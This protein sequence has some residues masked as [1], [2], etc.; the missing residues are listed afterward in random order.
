MSADGLLT[1]RVVNGEQSSLAMPTLSV[2]QLVAAGDDYY[3]YCVDEA[4]APHLFRYRYDET[5]ATVP[6]AELRVYA[7]EDSPTIRQAAGIFQRENP[8]VRVRFE[9]ALSDGSTLPNDA[10]QAL[11]TELL[12]G[13]GPD[14]LVLDGMPID[15]YRQKGILAD[16]G[17][18]LAPELQAGLLAN[19][20]SAYEADGTLQALP[21]R[22]TL[23]MI[24]ATEEVAAET[25]TLS[26]LADFLAGQESP[27][28][29]VPPDQI[30]DLLYPV[31]HR[32]WFRADGSFD[33]EACTRG[34]ADLA[35][36]LSLYGGKDPADIWDAAGDPI[37][38]ALGWSDDWIPFFIAPLT[39]MDSLVGPYSAINVRGEGAYTP[40]PR[41][42]GGIFYPR[43]VLGINASSGNRELAGSFVA[44][45][46]SE[47]VQSRSLA[48]GLPV[49][50]AALAAAKEC[51]PELSSQG[52]SFQRYGI[53]FEDVFRDGEERQHHLEA[54]W[55]D[56]VFL[57][58]V[59][60]AIDSADTPVM[61][62]RTVVE[63]FNQETAAFFAGGSSLED[64]MTALRQKLDIYLAE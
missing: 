48:D 60:D 58:G 8:D 18:L 49:N 20:A 35:R 34:L 57:A 43:V 1:E 33:E 53:S 14:L 40:Y 27:Q 55:P 39:S 41:G 23:P 63:I 46:L 4:N 52:A 32:E 38:G 7:L 10:L 29:G 36:I 3:V 56:A 24:L 51:P 64:T 25:A 50:R 11:S 26:G 12:A 13:T 22:F 47:D 28:I 54:Y 45:A 21:A 61:V 19:I 62:N 37:A 44:C 6:S 42:S 15:D 17:A 2:R 5:V 9:V 16:L 59:N 30:I 31:F